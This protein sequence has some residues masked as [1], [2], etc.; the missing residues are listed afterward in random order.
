MSKPQRWFC[1][2]CFE[3]LDAKSEGKGLRYDRL[4][5]PETEYCL[6]PKCYL[7]GRHPHTFLPN[8]LAIHLHVHAF[9]LGHA[10][11]G[12]EPQIRNLP[13]QLFPRLPVHLSR[14]FASPNAGS[15]SDGNRHIDGTTRALAAG[16]DEDG[17]HNQPKA[18]ET[19]SLERRIAL[20]EACVRLCEQEGRACEVYLSA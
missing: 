7:K 3:I 14:L 12:C 20:L 18:E 2:Q 5:S 17:A 15:D 19:S 13:K 4:N 1:D 16:R 11:E 8:R 6:C 9:A 10:P